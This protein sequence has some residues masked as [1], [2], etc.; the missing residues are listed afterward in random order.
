MGLVVVY[1]AVDELSALSVRDLLLQNSIP[2]VI[3]SEE[4]SAFGGAVGGFNCW[5]EVLVNEENIEKALELIGGFEGTLGE[6][7]ELEGLPPGK[8]DPEKLP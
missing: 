3:R 1:E 5:G 8:I 4:V 7:A 2:A 6:L